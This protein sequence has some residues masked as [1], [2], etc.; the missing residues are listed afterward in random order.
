MKMICT[1]CG[2]QDEPVT[3]GGGSCLLEI[4]LWFI[5]LIIAATGFPLFSILLLIPIAY[6]LSRFF[7]RKKDVC[8]AC[9]SEDIIPLDTPMAKKLLKDLEDDK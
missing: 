7:I 2:R 9:G 3:K 8:S 5:F 4:V 6:T 1:K